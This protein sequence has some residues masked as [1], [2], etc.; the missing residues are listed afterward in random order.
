MNTGQSG[1]SA[2]GLQAERYIMRLGERWGRRGEEAASPGWLGAGD[3]GKRPAGIGLT[4]EIQAAG[5]G[6]KRSAGPGRL[7]A[8]PASGSRAALQAASRQLG[9]GNRSWR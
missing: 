9:T 8:D 7:S 6:L 2:V 1:E 3:A 5:G 4:G